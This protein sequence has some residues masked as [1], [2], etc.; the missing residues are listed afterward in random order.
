M[1]VEKILE[2]QKFEDMISR[3]PENVLNHIVSFLQTKDQ[4]RYKFFSRKWRQLAA[5]N[6][7]ALSLMGQKF[8]EEQLSK[9]L[10]DDFHSLEVLSLIRCSGMKTM[11]LTS[12]KIKTLV[13]TIEF[14]ICKQ[15]K[16]V[17]LVGV[18]IDNMRFIDC[19]KSFPHLKVLIIGCCDFVGCVNISSTSLEKLSLCKFKKSTK[20]N[21][22]TPNLVEFNY[23]GSTTLAFSNMKCPN[24]L[25]AEIKFYTSRNQTFDEM[26]LHGLLDMIRWLKHSKKVRIR[27]NSGKDKK[28]D[29]K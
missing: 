17:Q 15:L 25:S 1:F 19:N 7:K 18:K 24:L 5:Q 8:S 10:M 4:S 9:I 27:S 29:N 23:S 26:W 6:Q 22:D 13:L 28:I 11:R 12:Y 2:K 3:M 21:I 14:G 16:Y 20:F